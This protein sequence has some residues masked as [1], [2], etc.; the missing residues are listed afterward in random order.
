LHGLDNLSVAGSV[1][2]HSCQFTIDTGSNISI[3]RPDILPEQQQQTIQPVS[4]SFRTVTGDKAPILGKGD[5]HVRIGSQEAVHPM[6]I[7][8]IEDE[9]I[10]GLDFLELHSCRLDLRDSVLYLNGDEIPL[11]KTG[12]CSVASAK[13]Y[14]AVLDTT[15][16]LPPH[17]EC[18][19]PARVE[20]LQSSELKWG[21]LEPQI[22]DATCAL[23]GLIVGR[24][25]VDL[26]QSTAVV[27][28]MNLSGQRRKVKK[29]TE[30][31][32][33]EP[34]ALG[35]NMFNQSVVGLERSLVYSTDDFTTTHQVI[36]FFNSIFP[37][38]DHTLI[39][40]L[41][42]GPLM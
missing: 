11:L 7:A 9:C 31:A 1:E 22:K 37:W 2:G 10:L 41:P 38:L 42:Y 16:S 6:W 36:P 34:I 19:A 32:N 23:Q 39:M 30:V 5:L 17:S 24:T 12:N 21:I 20:G 18:V 40:R 26:H 3:I 14:R 29:G 15:I 4:Q 35:V 28:L 33:C 27:R 8:D 25:L 13:T